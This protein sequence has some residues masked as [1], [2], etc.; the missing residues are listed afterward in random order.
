MKTIYYRV[1]V[2]EDEEQFFLIAMEILM[3]NCYKDYEEIIYENGFPE[4]IERKQKQND[5]IIA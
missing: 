1:A 2:S 4:K 5:I 3:F